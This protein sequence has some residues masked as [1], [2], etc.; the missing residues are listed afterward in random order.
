MST[1]ASGLW[2]PTPAGIDLSQNQNAQIIASV[3]VVTFIALA[4]VLLRLVAR[5]SRSGPGLAA[6]DYV[7]AVAFVSAHALWRLS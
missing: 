6:D 1:T 4:A 7:I 3:T 5:I 2:G